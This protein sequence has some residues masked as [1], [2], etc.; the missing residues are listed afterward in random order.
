MLYLKCLSQNVRLSD[1]HSVQEFTSR[2]LYAR[3]L[4]CVINGL[5][6]ISLVVIFW[7]SLWD[8]LY[9]DVYPENVPLSLLISWI[10]G[11]SILLIFY[12]IQDILQRCHS[13]LTSSVGAFIFRAVYSYLLSL[14]YVFHYR[15]YWDAYSYF[16]EDIDY[17]V[18]LGISLFSIAVYRYVCEG[19]WDALNESVPFNVTVTAKFDGFFLLNSFASTKQVSGLLVSA[20]ELLRFPLSVLSLTGRAAKEMLRST[21]SRN[22]RLSTPSGTKKL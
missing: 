15:S 9:E 17:R 20:F 4:I 13:R 19:S 10:V 7:A 14:A 2:P 1:P 11:N 3:L 12:F 16:T 5:F 18:F 22:K 21:I 6:T 8:I